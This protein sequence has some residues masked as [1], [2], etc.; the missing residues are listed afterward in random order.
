MDEI[1]LQQLSPPTVVKVARVCQFP[2]KRRIYSPA[3]EEC[4]RLN[5]SPQVRTSRQLVVPKHRRPATSRIFDRFWHLLGS[6]QRNVP[7][8][9]SRQTFAWHNTIL[10]I[11]DTRLP[12]IARR[13]TEILGL[14]FLYAFFSKMN[15]LLPQRFLFEN[16]TFRSRHTTVCLPWNSFSSSCTFCRLTPSATT[17]YPKW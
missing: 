4:G 3:V 7:I 15:L 6:P 11:P 14:Q 10:K 12:I 1:Y 2:K 16:M 13:V 5:P 8:Y 17:W 9:K